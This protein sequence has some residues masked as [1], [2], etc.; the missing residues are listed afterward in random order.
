MIATV[1]GALKAVQNV[2]PEMALKVVYP[3]EPTM[4]VFEDV[5]APWLAQGGIWN[6]S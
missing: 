2:Y 6:C 1:Y 4:P 3:V 5:L